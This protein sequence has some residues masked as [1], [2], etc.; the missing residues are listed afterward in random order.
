MPGASLNQAV[1]EE[2]M[3]PQMQTLVLCPLPQV[4][5]VGRSRAARERQARAYWD[6]LSRSQEAWVL[7]KMKFAEMGKL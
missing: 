1:L 4:A 6:R 3:H 2:S 7:R 5:A